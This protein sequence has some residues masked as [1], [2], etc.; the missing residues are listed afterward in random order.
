VH[1]GVQGTASPTSDLHS[2]LGV[3]HAHSNV[4]ATGRGDS[5]EIQMLT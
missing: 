1:Y 3:T 2:A 4:D 5:C